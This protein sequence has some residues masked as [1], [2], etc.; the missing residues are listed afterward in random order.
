M[1]QA[2]K[3]VWSRGGVLG[4]YQGLIPWVGPSLVS[5]YF[6]P[7]SACSLRSSRW[8]KTFR[9]RGGALP[10]ELT[11]FPSLLPFVLLF[12]RHGSRLPP[13]EPFSSSPLQKSNRLPQGW[14]SVLLFQVC[15]EEWEEESL[16]LM[17]RWVSSRDL[18]L[19]LSHLPFFH[20]TQPTHLSSVLSSPRPELKELTL[21][22]VRSSFRI[23]HLHEN[24]RDHS[25][26]D[27]CHRSQASHDHRRLHGY[28]PKGRYRWYQQGCERGGDQAVHQL[29]I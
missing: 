3:T 21:I 11:I 19:S 12:R 7:L 16:R 20:R 8:K 9:A 28:L 18:S 10:D 6:L 25:T 1:L 17:R 14:V 13:K 23:L 29:G 5:L 2:Y 26:Q 27:R 15:W 4:F 24:R 22:L